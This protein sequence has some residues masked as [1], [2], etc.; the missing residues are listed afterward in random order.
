MGAGL[1]WR[2]FVSLAFIE[3][4]TSGSSCSGFSRGSASD[5]NLAL[6]EGSSTA[7]AEE[8]RVMGRVLPFDESAGSAMGAGREPIAL[9]VLPSF[10]HSW[11]RGRQTTSSVPA[12]FISRM[13]DDA[14]VNFASIACASSTSVEALTPRRCSSTS[15][16]SSRTCSSSETRTSSGNPSPSTLQSRAAILDDASTASRADHVATWSV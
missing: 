10:W 14:L 7:H 15:L 11:I 13:R 8:G 9:Q 16:K 5:A 6:R 3:G 2:A 1:A 4:F 12:S